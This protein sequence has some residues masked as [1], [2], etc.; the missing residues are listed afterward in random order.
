MTTRKPKAP[1]AR[2]AT[3]HSSDRVKVWHGES[4]PMTLC[5]F[6]AQA[7]LITETFAI[8]RG[9]RTS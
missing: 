1:C 4:V 9:Q 2:I 3:A 8:V 6:H 5:G 7:C